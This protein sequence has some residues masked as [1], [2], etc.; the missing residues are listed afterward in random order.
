M[1]TASAASM[2][3]NRQP[4]IW[5]PSK[6]GYWAGSGIECSCSDVAGSPLKRKF[7][8]GRCGAKTRAGTP[9][10]C[11]RTFKGGRC[12]L[13]GGASYSATDKV[14][15]SRE[16]GRTFLKTGPRTPE[17]R[18][19]ALSNLARGR[20]PGRVRASSPSSKSFCPD[21]S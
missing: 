10:R 1:P 12:V 13:H 6:E 2:A 19:K 17:G 14:R 16:T 9:C 21:S 15:I 18:A 11:R 3:A 20:L 4:T 8:D 5:K 7:P